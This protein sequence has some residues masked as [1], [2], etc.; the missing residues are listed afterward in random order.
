[1]LLY[2]D[3]T[4]CNGICASSPDLIAASAGYRVEA[5]IG[6]VHSSA[7]VYITRSVADVVDVVVC[8]WVS[9]GQS[10]SILFYSRHPETRLETM[11]NAVW[12]AVVTKW[13]LIDKRAIAGQSKGERAW[14]SRKRLVQF[15]GCLIH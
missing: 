5:S 9:L 7:N 3:D 13:V 10:W 12:N 2:C 11:H 1:M 8:M 14:S 6:R 15:A 4:A